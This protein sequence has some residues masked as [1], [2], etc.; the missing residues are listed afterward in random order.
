VQNKRCIAF[1]FVL[2]GRGAGWQWDSTHEWWQRQQII[3]Y[4]DDFVILSR[5]HTEEALAWTR[6]VMTALG[7]SLNEAK[8]SVR[9]APARKLRFSWL[10]AGTT[11]FFLKGD[12]WYLG[13][14]PSRK[15]VPST[16]KRVVKSRS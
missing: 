12:R 11:P 3:A 10:R 9:D 4:A 2:S 1:E 14:A 6:A 15:S 16:E 8:T 5:G 13:A 7:L